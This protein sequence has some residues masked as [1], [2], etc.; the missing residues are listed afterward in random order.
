MKA[1]PENR[2]PKMTTA[3]TT[4]TTPFRAIAAAMTDD[5]IRSVI[6]R[7]LIDWDALTQ[8]Q[9]RDASGPLV[10]LA[11]HLAHESQC[12]VSA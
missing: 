3:T 7:M 12:G 8:Q 1:N 6:R 9:K 2:E 10:E 11:A 5:E 4:T